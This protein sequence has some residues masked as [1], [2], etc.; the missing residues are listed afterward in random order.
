MT[1]KTKINFNIFGLSAKYFIPL[2]II[3]LIAAYGDFLPTKTVFKADNI[4]YEATSFVG[5]CAF[6]WTIGGFLFWFG[7]SLPFVGKY[8]GGSVLFSLFGSAFM[9][10]MGLIPETL[11][12]GIDV[13]VKTGF[14]DMYI[15]FLLVGSVLALDRRILLKTTARY[16]P[17]VIGSQIFALGFAVI[18]GIITGFGAKDGLFFV[19]APTMSGGSAGA[20]TTIPALYSDLSGTDMTGLA[21]QFMGY[22]S[23]SNVI[24][25][26]LGAVVGGIT[27]NTLW[28]NGQG[29]ILDERKGKMEIDE[30]DEL[31]GTTDNYAK[32]AGGLFTAL[33]LYIGGAILGK[34]P[35]LGVIP[36]LAWTIILTIIIK[37]T[38]IIDR[39]TAQYG[40]Y[41]MNF[42]LKVILP[43]L[44]AGIGIAAMDLNLVVQAF[45]V[46]AFIVI[47]V[48]VI[49]AFIGAGLFGKLWGLFPFEAGVTAGLCCCNIGGSG[50][51]AVLTGANRMNLLAFA[52]ISTRIGG[53]LMVIWIGIL[54]RLLM[55]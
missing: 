53:A 30:S 3:V 47:L 22:V 4:K 35:I 41:S 50:D 32:L 13:L 1:K 45:T 24:A 15:A 38:N 5:T 18:A 9:K 36:G 23:I 43:M 40:V 37:A 52:S 2:A 34:L 42:A 29:A 28:F 39:N 26:V 54:Y 31:P 51:I 46:R 44:L 49:G 55:L 19:A 25:I 17:T 20:L 11:S 14:Q 48:T 10:Y 6:L 33:V 7:N 27:Q 12:N 8:L 16:I 21:G